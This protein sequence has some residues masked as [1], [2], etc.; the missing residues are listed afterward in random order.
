MASRAQRAA[1]A[2]VARSSDR[3]LERTAGSRA[4]QRLLFRRLARSY[5]PGSLD[6]FTGDI[7]FA[8]RR[9]EA[10]TCWTLHVARGE[11]VVQEG[12]TP[13]AA[14]VLRVGI[15]DL[16]R[17]G[18]GELDPMRALLAGRLDVEGDFTIASRLGELFGRRPRTGGSAGR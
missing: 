1:R 15:A 3:R 7:V 18:T 17:I 9:G 11:A 14:V 6:G 4:G 16:V 8:V 2:F 13:H 10:T 5:V 12:E